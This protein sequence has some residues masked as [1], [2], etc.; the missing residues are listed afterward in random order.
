[1]SF[2]RA[3]PGHFWRAPKPLAWSA[4]PT[5]VMSL[6]VT[7]RDITILADLA[8]YRFLSLRQLAALRFPSRAAARMRLGRLDQEG[9]IHKL[10]MPARPLDRSSETVYALSRAG[11]HRYAYVRS[12]AVPRHLTGERRR[13]ALFL[14]HTI[15]RNNL[16]GCFERLSSSA[17]LQLL[18]WKQ[19]RCDVSIR[20]ATTRSDP[21]PL[22]PDGIMK[23]SIDS[24]VN[25]FAVEIDMGTVA[26]R[27][28]LERYRSYYR[29][30]RSGHRKRIGP[31]PFRVLTITPDSRRS[32]RLMRA[33]QKATSA[34][35]SQLFWFTEHDSIDI[36]QPRSVLRARWRVSG[37]NDEYRLFN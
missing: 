1:M 2:W 20:P 14:S 24:K 22:V 25:A 26:T 17:E 32:Q 21:R 13:T 37:T 18:S 5:R 6:R 34:T 4:N 10:Y 16:R 29:F 23:V 3:H 33:A 36:D 30:W 31:V 28:M 12:C 9:L 11:A 35:S 27:K 19:R 7:K 8:S 15:A